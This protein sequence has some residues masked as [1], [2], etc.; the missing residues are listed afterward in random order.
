[1]SIVLALITISIVLVS[2]TVGNGTSPE[3]CYIRGRVS[4]DLFEFPSE[5][6]IEY[7]IHVTFGN[8]LIISFVPTNAL[9]LLMTIQSYTKTISPG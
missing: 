5:T 1:M 8:T 7:R 2:I 6:R 9:M 3:G 4:P